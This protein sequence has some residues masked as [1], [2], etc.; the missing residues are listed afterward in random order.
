MKNLDFQKT[1]G[2]LQRRVRGIAAFSGLGWGSLAA[3]MT[4]LCGAWAD[5]VFELSPALRL[6]ALAAA[7]LLGPALAIFVAWRSGRLA[8]PSVLAQ[9]LDQAGAAHGEIVAGVDLLHD[10]RVFVPPAAGLASIAVER[11]ANLARQVPGARVAPW[12]PVLAPALATGLAAGVVALVALALPRMAD[13]LW[14]RFSDPFGDHPPYSAVRFRVEPGDLSVVYGQGVEIRAIVAGAPVDRLDLVLEPEGAA[15][16]RVPMFQEASGRWRA[17]L[18][19]VIAPARYFV[20]AERARARSSRH[21]ID[22]I[23][24]PRL[25][26][27]RFR[28]TPPA[29]T[30]RSAYEG[31]LPAGGLAG[32]AGTHVEAWATSNRPLLSGTL[33]LAGASAPRTLELV[34]TAPGAQEVHG[35]FEIR[36][37]GKIEVRVRDAAGQQSQDAVSASVVLLH[38]ERPFI[39]ITEPRELS[40]ATPDVMLPVVLAAE[41]DFGI[42][43]VQ[44]FRALNG[45]RALPIDLPLLSPSPTQWNDQTYLPLAEFGVRAGDEI[46]LFARVEDNDP[47]GAKGSE[48]T[49]VRLRII[50]RE[51]YDRLVRARQGALA[52]LARYQE[53]QRRLEALAGEIDR[54]HDELAKLPTGT[55][56]EQ[57]KQKQLEELARRFRDETAAIRESAKHP[58]PLAIDQNLSHELEDLAKALEK[59]AQEAEKLAGETGLKN[60]AAAQR[61]AELRDRLTGGRKQLEQNALEPLDQLARV[62]PLMEDQARF[63]QLYL[64]QRDLAQRLTSF[65]G[66]DREDEPASKARMRDLEAEQKQIRSELGRLLDDI[67]EHARLL[68][69][70]PQLTKLRETAQEFATAVRSSGAAEA[71]TDAEEALAAFAGTRSFDAATKAAGILEKFLSQCSS[72]GALNQA[73][74]ACLAFQPGLAQNLGNSIEQML[75]DAGFPS[76]DQIGKPGFGTGA[77]TGNGYSARQNNMNNVGLYGSLPTLVSSARQGSSRTNTTGGPGRPQGTTVARRAPE[78][79]ASPGA[80]RGAGASQATIPAPYRRRVADYFE[81]IA[82]E[83]GDR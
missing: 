9:R 7:V 57:A 12:R 79:T 23:T 44:L 50:P 36:A 34:P 48:S 77:G 82:D 5:L 59:L 26:G 73:G 47:A 69:D 2:R 56:L 1:L 28:V 72:N 14:Q 29:Y 37:D 66:R 33:E 42:A 53:A 74:Q 3:F 83:L 6:A 18:A 31:V 43:R 20:S 71:M 49:V 25:S 8:V 80:L 78:V 67:E 76:L 60:A 68:P 38:D 32:L 58:L 24:V 52:L 70:D 51:V 27:V 22:V 81:R 16:E 10:T 21:K 64:H 41:D 75:A 40:F 54:L 30:R 55:T 4:V 11:A 15:P 62:Y 63:V 65:K 17:A 46:T 19:N 61:L 13:A 39:R 35:S 45:S